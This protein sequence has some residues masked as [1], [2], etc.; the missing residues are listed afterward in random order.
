[1][2]PLVF[3]ASVWILGARRW[4]DSSQEH[5]DFVYMMLGLLG[6]ALVS[7]L[8]R[9]GAYALRLEP[10]LYALPLMLGAISCVHAARRLVPDE[11]DAQRLA[12]M[13]L[14]GYALS[15][16]AFALVLVRY[17]RSPRRFTV[18]TRWR[19]PSWGWSSMSPRCATD[20]HPAFLYL[21]VGAVVAGRLGAHY[22]LAERLHAIEEAV[23]QAARLS[24]SPPHPVPG[25][26]RP[27]SQHGTRLVV[28]LVRQELG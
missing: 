21:A 7:C 16:L 5:L 8:F 1:M 12:L 23:R 10:S 18:E 20:R 25:N 9:T 27:D 28:A 17:R 15:G 11:P 6:F 19:S 24:R 26:P 3:L 14:G 2:S 22:F 13:R 4:G